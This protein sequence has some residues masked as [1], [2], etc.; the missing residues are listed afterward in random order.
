MLCDSER[1]REWRE[2][3]VKGGG[4]EGRR[5]WRE[6]GGTYTFTS[7]GRR[8]ERRGGRGGGANHM[9]MRKGLGIFLENREKPA[10]TQD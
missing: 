5:E 9:Y 3:G 2:E 7:R 8:R 10:A 4:S 6:E 1:R